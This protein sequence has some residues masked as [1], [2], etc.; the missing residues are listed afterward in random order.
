MELDLLQ[1][2]TRKIY[3]LDGREYTIRRVDARSLLVPQRFD[4]F[5]KL[6]YIAHHD[7]DLQD[8]LKV[9]TEHIK[10]FNPDGREPGREDKNGV[11]DFVASFN[12]MIEYF[13]VNDFDD[14]VSM[15]P[16]DKNGVILDGAHRVAALAYHGREVT[17]AQFSEVVAKCDFDFTFFKNRGLSWG[18]CD[19]IA[20]EMTKWVP[21]LLAACLWPRINMKQQQL[22]ISSLK[23][24]H[25]I[26]YIKEIKCDLQSLSNF[27]GYI[28]RH[29]SWTKRP[30]YV[31]DKSSR[32]YGNSCLSVVY[33]VSGHDLNDILKEK[34]G[35]R[36]LLGKGKDS[37]HITD[38]HDETV[39][40]AN[41]TLSSKGIDTWLTNKTRNRIN[42][43]TEAMKE[44]WLIFKKVQWLSIKGF[45]SRH[46]RK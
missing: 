21:D 10:A 22:V 2:H 9:Y 34:D 37:I 39:D 14:A 23:R 30:D 38:N 5:A 1:Q 20:L 32:I 27:V 33:F 18:I 25:T 45:I 19:K 44:R 8:A 28:Y 29:Q 13:K 41:V 24:E 17:I 43:I 36:S 26:A 42:R 16:V 3:R 6:Y 12:R 7:T 40:I 15:V 4:L 35:I 11:E 46:I 31:L